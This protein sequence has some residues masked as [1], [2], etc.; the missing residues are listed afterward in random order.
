MM[1]MMT[2][3]MRMTMTMRKTMRMMMTMRIRM[4]MT[5]T[6]RMTMMVVGGGG[7]DDEDDDQLAE[8]VGTDFDPDEYPVCGE[9]HQSPVDIPLASTVSSAEL[10]NFKFHG[11]SQIPD[12]VSMK[13]INKEHTGLCSSNKHG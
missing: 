13:L 7:G 8:C 5:M 1:M 11:Y 4:R 6:M 10:H 3:T 12:S 2:I 9:S